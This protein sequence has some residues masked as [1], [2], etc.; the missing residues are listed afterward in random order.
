MCFSI[1]EILHKNKFM[2]GVSACPVTTD[3]PRI[4]KHSLRLMKRLDRFGSTFY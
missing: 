3:A 4:L 2:Y 1:Q